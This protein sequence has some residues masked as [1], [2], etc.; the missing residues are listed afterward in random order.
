M[1]SSLR[2]HIL[3][4]T[5]LPSCLISLVLG[6]YINHARNIDL[7][8]FITERGHAT[9]RQ[10]AYTAKI[11]LQQHQPGII[12]LW[13]NSALEE[14]GLRSI[15]IVNK[16]GSPLIHAGPQ[17]LFKPPYPKELKEIKL[18]DINSFIM[19][20]SR[21]PLISEILNKKNIRP[22]HQQATLQYSR[23][24]SSSST[25]EQQL[26]VIVEYNNNGYLLKQFESFFIQ[27]SLLIIFFILAGVIAWRLSQN[28]S[29][30][31]QSLNEGL[32][33]LAKG[34][35]SFNKATMLTQDMQGLADN[36]E[37]AASAVNREFEDMR[38]NV[39]LTTS[40]LKQTIETIEIQNI[41][42]SLAKKSAT[43]ASQ[44]KSEFLANTSHEI[45]TPLNGIIGFT[46]LLKRTPL[47]Q[48]QE[49]YVETIHQSSEGLLAIINDILDFSK[50]EA[51]K[52]ILDSTP[53]NLRQVFEDITA[54]FGP[55]AYDKGI[56]IALMIYQD[57][58]TQIIGDPLRIKQIISNL[59][60]NAVKFTPSG[61]IAIRVSLES[62]TDVETQ[63]SVSISDTGIGMTPEQ[64]QR[65]FEAFTQANTSIS[66]QYG[67]TGLGLSIVKNLIRQM[68]GE[69]HADSKLND[70]TTFS[71]N[72]LLKKSGSHISD[73]HYNWQDKEVAYFEPHALINLSTQHLLEDFGCKVHSTTQLEEL[74]KTLNEKNV[75]SCIYSVGAKSDTD[76]NI[77]SIQQLMNIKASRILVISPN[78]LKLEKFC[79]Q[80]ERI[81]FC[82]KPISEQ[83]LHKALQLSF[84]QQF[85]LVKIDQSPQRPFTDL[86][87]LIADDQPANLKL[88]HILLSDLGA[89]VMTA[90]NGE[91][92]IQQ[93]ESFE[94]DII[95]MDIQMPVID[96]IKATEAIN[97]Y[98]SLNQD[99]PIV[100]LT[101]NVLEEE[102][103]HL[104][105]THFKEYLTKPINEDELIKTI[106]AQCKKQ[107][108]LAIINP[109]LSLKLANNK[110]DLAIEMHR[111]FIIDIE[112]ASIDLEKLKRDEHYSAIVNLV[113]KLHGACC[114]TG[115][116]TFKKSCKD[117]E[118]TINSN[119]PKA[120]ADGLLEKLLGN[121]NDII[122][123]NSN[124]N[125]TTL[126]NQL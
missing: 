3:L 100:A 108:S 53:F 2:S 55:Q 17:T 23:N 52:L 115:A 89:K 117:L 113:H 60:S 119:K 124:N 85:G 70:G 109:A 10:F 56:E 110:K 87:I 29:K 116:P 28:L 31:I 74:Q 78:N 118:D 79:Q 64:L 41:E 82:S 13:A 66:R 77:L 67:G 103:R 104:L 42:L 90:V 73:F 54:L 121:A 76:K 84:R 7:Q 105:K 37:S 26:W 45:R 20:L 39:E 106:K 72:L 86:H 75:D 6:L 9:T 83:R 71:F 94:F 24:T 18:G 44:I 43:E 92:A 34:N 59:L 62:E 46:K 22:E 95:F 122:E 33:Q 4:I 80:H 98:S 102:K 91:V 123:W 30:D 32:K 57:V 16:Q 38:H 21:H 36:L 5:L 81:N 50:I 25:H 68:H 49:D 14:K 120:Q 112:A 51:G 114:Y 58:P 35:S 61:T 97:A 19:P 96:G 107:E 27:N 99:T 93:S 12:Q 48:Q 8:E 69:V 65:L 111:M 47:S 63:I 15:S 88:L 101:A 40:D 1:L 11:A 126:I 125:I